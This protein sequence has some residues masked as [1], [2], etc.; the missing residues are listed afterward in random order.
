[1]FLVYHNRL[2]YSF[3]LFISDCLFTRKP[4]KPL[5]ALHPNSIIHVTDTLSY[6]VS[7]MSSITCN[8][9]QGKWSTWPHV[10]GGV[11]LKSH[12]SA[13]V[14]V[15]N[16]HLCKGRRK[17]EREITGVERYLKYWKAGKTQSFDHCQAAWYPESLCGQLNKSD[18]K[19]AK[20][21][22]QKEREARLKGEWETKGESMPF[23]NKLKLP[24]YCFQT[25]RTLT[26]QCFYLCPE[27]IFRLH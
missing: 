19:W 8:L 6:Y 18:K 5:P 16:G 21:Q 3:L 9:W 1:M 23:N 7:S 10:E 4:S 13:Y 22:A 14:L 20:A 26:Q 17:C 27:K 11:A 12:G 2:S 25:R 24:Y 15:H